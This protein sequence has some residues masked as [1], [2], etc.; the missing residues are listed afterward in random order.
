[1]IAF[2]EQSRQLRARLVRH[3]RPDRRQLVGLLLDR[4]D[5]LRVLVP[6]RDID[7]LRR[8]VE[9]AVAVVVPEVATLRALDGDRVDRVLHAPRVEDVPLRVLDD[10]PAERLARERAAGLRRRHL[11]NPTTAT[12]AL[13]SF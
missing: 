8:E 1:L 12:E 4:G 11:F 9:V 3:R 10:L 7:E 6:E 5:D 2:R 13:R